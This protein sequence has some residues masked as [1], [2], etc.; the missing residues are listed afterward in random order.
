MIT[1]REILRQ[2][3]SIITQVVSLS[4]CDSQNFPTVQPLQGGGVQVTVKDANSLAVALKNVSYNHIYRTLEKAGA[5]HLK[6]IDGSLIQ[7]LYTFQSDHLWSHRLAFFPSP[8]LESFQTDQE[9]YLNDDIFADMLSRP[10]VPFPIRFDFNS[11]PS[12]H[13]EVDHPKSHLT[14]G[15][16]KDC[17]IPVS[18]PL[19]PYDFIGFIIRN[20]YNT[21]TRPFSKSLNLAGEVFAETITVSECSIPHF[22]LR[23]SHGAS[24]L[25][26]TRSLSIIS[27]D[28]QRKYKQRRR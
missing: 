14:L 12:V 25:S 11:S 13:V 24:P 27:R 21:S 2:A 22:R 23:Y 7:M 9:S 10:V 1:Q 8:D 4:L 28:R 16:Y 19:T 5:Y 3:R 18:A 26:A 17:R 6:M 15:Q 20:F